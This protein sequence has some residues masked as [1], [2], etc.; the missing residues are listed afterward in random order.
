M[1]QYEYV[2]LAVNI[3]VM[4]HNSLLSAVCALL[5]SQDP[6]K[7]PVLAA[8]IREGIGAILLDASIVG[9]ASSP[10]ADALVTQDLNA[11][12]LALGEQPGGRG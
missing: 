10:Q 1:D 4:R 12:L 5:E 7:K 9:Q 3:L 11:M 6:A 8:N 2:K